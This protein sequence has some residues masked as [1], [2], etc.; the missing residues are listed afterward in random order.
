MTRCLTRIHFIFRINFFDFL[1]NFFFCFEKEIDLKDVE[2]IN[3]IE[4]PPPIEKARNKR[5][6]DS[7]ETIEYDDVSMVRETMASILCQGKIKSIYIIEKLNI[8]SINYN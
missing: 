6:S 4:S 2:S 1:N 5:L 3:L 7:G 8:K